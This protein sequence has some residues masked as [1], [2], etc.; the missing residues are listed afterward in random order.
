MHVPINYAT[1]AARVTVHCLVDEAIAH[2]TSLRK[3][4]R[5]SGLRAG[6]RL[7]ILL[8][9]FGVLFGGFVLI[10]HGGVQGLREAQRK[11]GQTT[12][13]PLLLGGSEAIAFVILCVTTLIIAKIEDRKFSEY[14]LPPR[15]ALGKDFWFG[16]VLGF[17][18]ISGTLLIMFL[19]HG[20]RVT[21]LAIHGTTILS[22]LFG[23]WHNI[24]PRWTI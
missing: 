13:T 18:A 21:G 9:L 20:F 22:S 6:W 19:L 24:S 1:Y 3:I 8:V 7:L 10:W 23:W 11:L 2:A 14:G 16:A 12:V 17:L 4:L 5:P 15:Q